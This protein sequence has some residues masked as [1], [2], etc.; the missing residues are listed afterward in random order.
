M[1]CV[2]ADELELLSDNG[3]SL[4]SGKA[5]LTKLLFDPNP[6]SPFVA[7]P[8][9]S[10]STSSS[11]VGRQNKRAELASLLESPAASV[12]AVPPNSANG[13]LWVDINA[14]VMP[15]GGLQASQI[16]GMGEY[17]RWL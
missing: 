16:V 8:S 1:A 12:R 5:A 6:Y 15:V 7:L 4:D 9:T 10:S 3:I 17:M 2:L 14:K 13:R 11:I